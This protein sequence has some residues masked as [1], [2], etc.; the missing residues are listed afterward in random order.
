MSMRNP[1]IV[2]W[3]A[4]IIIAIASLPSALSAQQQSANVALAGDA[5][6]G[7]PLYADT[8]NCY[9]CHGFDAQTGERRLL[10]MNFPQ[11][12]FILFVQ[13]SPLPLMPAFPDVPAQDLADIY[14]Y[15]RSIPVDA[16]ALADVPL[17]NAI[18][19]RKKT[20]LGN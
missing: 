13:N 4:A 11:E 3:R 8:Y 6:R 16:P 14:A 19:D 12:A 18:R 2:R 5:A 9:A 10:P 17:L 15:I 20:A 7:K 1:F